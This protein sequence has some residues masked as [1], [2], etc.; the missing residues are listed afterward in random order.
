V[1][2]A[3]G[4][5]QDRLYVGC[6]GHENAGTGVADLTRRTS[7]VVDALGRRDVLDAR[8]VRAD[9]IVSAIAVDDTLGLGRLHTRPF[10]ADLGP[11][12]VD[13]DDAIEGDPFTLLVLTGLAESAVFVDGAFR[14]Q[15]DA[16]NAPWSRMGAPEQRVL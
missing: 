5:G 6:V 9:L 2:R 8:T 15:I 16:F 14:D 3:A 7:I 13:V 11:V 10:F 12:A 1:A 4:A